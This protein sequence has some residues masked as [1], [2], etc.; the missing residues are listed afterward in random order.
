MSKRKATDNLD[1][2]QGSKQPSNAVVGTALENAKSTVTMI[3]RSM[4]AKVNP[5]EMTQQEYARNVAEGKTTLQQRESYAAAHPDQLCH[6]SCQGSEDHQSM[7]YRCPRCLLRALDIIDT[8]NPGH[9]EQLMRSTLETMKDAGDLGDASVDEMM[10]SFG[11]LT[12]DDAAA[13]GSAAGS[14]AGK[15]GGRRT[16][17]RRKG[18]SSR[19]RVKRRTH[20]KKKHGK[21]TKGR[22]H[23]RGTSR[24]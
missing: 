9:G 12:T 21:K 24:R 5:P 18:R 2:K 16:R 1:D 4:A 8:A 14:A 7:H 19:H 6:G 15:K 11:N 22:K 20:R 10:A 13:A 23:R 3:T 17:H